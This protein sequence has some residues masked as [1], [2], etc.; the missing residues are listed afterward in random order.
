M[1]N[2]VCKQFSVYMYNTV[3]VFLYFHFVIR[4]FNFVLTCLQKFLFCSSEICEL[5]DRVLEKGMRWFNNMLPAFQEETWTS[6]GHMPEPEP[7]WTTLADGPSWLW[8]LLAIL[9]LGKPLQVKL[10]S[11]YKTD[12]LPVK[13]LSSNSLIVCSI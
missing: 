10:T 12:F 1:Y 5:H 13:M 3:C 6:I 2:S 8:W 9:P 7:N 11:F 4:I